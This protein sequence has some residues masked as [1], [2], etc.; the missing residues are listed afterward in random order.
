M[1]AEVALAYASSRGICC[2]CAVDYSADGCSLGQQCQESRDLQLDDKKDGAGAG[3][4]KS[5][6]SLGKPLD[7]LLTPLLVEQW[8]ESKMMLCSIELVVLCVSLVSEKP[9]HAI[10]IGAKKVEC[11]ARAFYNYYVHQPR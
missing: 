5:K 11:L 3:G 2:Y 4:V 10:L 9:Y 1:Q 6:Y 8:S 7:C